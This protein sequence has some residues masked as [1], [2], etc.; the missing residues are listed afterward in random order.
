[1]HNALVLLNGD[2]SPILGAEPGELPVPE[3]GAA[4]G[5]EAVTTVT[6]VPVQP[7]AAAQPQETGFNMW[8]MYGIW[9]VVIVGFYFLTIRPQRQRD[10]KMKEMQSN[11]SVGD[12]V[13][14]NG[15]M[16]GRVAD[17]GH[18]CFIVEFGTNR[19]I[20]IPI[21][22]SDVLGIG[23]PNMSPPPDNKI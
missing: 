14:T 11:I 22:K 10:K 20:R 8:W 19:G 17:V 15:G 5:Q 16:Y 9:I 6:E 4:T 23:T 7:P 12:N 3:N 1:M 13:L 18:D 2:L 21:R